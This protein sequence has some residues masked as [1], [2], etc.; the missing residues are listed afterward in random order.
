MYTSFELQVGLLF[1]GTIG[2]MYVFFTFI[3]KIQTTRNKIN[4]AKQ[5]ETEHIKNIASK[6]G[7][8]MEVYCPIVGETLYSPITNTPCLWYEIELIYQDFSVQHSRSRNNQSVIP[9]FS[10]IIELDYS[11]PCFLAQSGYKIPI[12]IKDQKIIDT[13]TFE[14]NISK[15]NKR[16]IVLRYLSQERTKK[17]ITKNTIHGILIDKLPLQ[18]IRLFA[19][20]EKILPLN[21]PI[22][23]IGTVKQFP[24]GSNLLN[25][26]S[27]ER[28][29]TLPYTI[30]GNM[31]TTSEKHY[32]ATL[33]KKIKPQFFMAAIL[34]LVIVILCSILFNQSHH[35]M[36]IINKN[37][38]LFGNLFK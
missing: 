3:K 25:D 37:I 22:Y 7:K 20:K 8:T 21:Q 28:Y 29:R 27:M 12:N 2:A 36:S 6:L 11:D 4:I 16:N 1:M 10:A 31:D 14:W 26:K 32:I 24:L 38:Y 9:N 17:A 19:L 13:R 35:L 33:S 18:E 15:K 30:D 5:E 34:G 23:L